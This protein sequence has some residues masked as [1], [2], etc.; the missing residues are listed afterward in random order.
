M[1][2][3]GD[4]GLLTRP[5]KK[6]VRVELKKRRFHW[7]LKNGAIAEVVFGRSSQKLWT[8]IY[9]PKQIQKFTGFRFYPFRA[10]AIV[11]ARYKAH[12]PKAISYKTVQG[13]PRQVYSVG[14]LTFD[15]EGQRHKLTAYNWQDLDEKLKY[16]A[17]IFTDL[18]AGKETYGGGRELAIPLKAE[19][20]DGDVVLVDFNRTQNFYCAHTPYWHC[21]TGLQENL[22]VAVNAGE[23][24][25]LKK[26]VSR[27]R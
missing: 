20:K 15:L 21:P 24:V 9:D 23:M 11:N 7:N 14:S 3:K 4:Y 25:P 12:V 16:I 1:V 5:G 27:K 8:Y 18:K 22:L 13:D 6:D 2:H 10:K 26:I 19:L 17:V